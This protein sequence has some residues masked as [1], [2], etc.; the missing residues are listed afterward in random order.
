MTVTITQ[1]IADVLKREG[2]YANI[3]ADRG[4]ETNFGITAQ[5][6]RANGYTGS[7]ATMPVAIAESIYRA[8]FWVQ[9]GFDKVADLC[10]D[11]AAQMFDIGVNMG[12]AK[13]GSLVQ[14]ALNVLNRGATD[15]PDLKIDGQFGAVARAAL[16]SYLQKRAA[17]QGPAVLILAVKGLR[18]A[19]YVEIAEKTRARRHLSTA[20]SRAC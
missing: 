3:P 15:Y 11:L 19:G 12:T 10:P 6:A 17:P 18:T 7:M 14:R 5:V 2:G 4:G 9:P 20:G 8:Q 13:A 16:T 1:L